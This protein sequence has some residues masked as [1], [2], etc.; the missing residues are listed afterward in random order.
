MLLQAADR[1]GPDL[2]HQ[3]IDDLDA[4]E[5]ALVYGAVK[6]LAGERLAVQRA[7]RIAVEEAADLVF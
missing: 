5:I 6:A 7:I 2:L 4:G 3:P 1:P